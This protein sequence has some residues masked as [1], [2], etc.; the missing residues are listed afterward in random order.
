[1]K[2]SIDSRECRVFPA[3]TSGPA[4]FYAPRPVTARMR[5]VTRVVE[6]APASYRPRHLC[7]LM[8][9][10]SP[11]APAR[12][13]EV[14]AETKSSAF[15]QPLVI[16]LFLTLMPPVGVPLLWASPRY[17]TAGKAA[18]TGFVAFVMLLATIALVAGTGICR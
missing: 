14:S 18:V 7:Q 11:E 12:V 8:P 13:I 3:Y 2:R 4:A 6:D 15:E 1:M 10:V 16:A 17:T 9:Q 5:R